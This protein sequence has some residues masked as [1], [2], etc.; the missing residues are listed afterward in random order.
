MEAHLVPQL[1]FHEVAS[2]LQESMNPA[3]GQAC[4][5]IYFHIDEQLPLR[6]MIPCDRFR[7]DHLTEL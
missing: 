4:M 6:N 3:R 2:T 7:S 5:K 1:F